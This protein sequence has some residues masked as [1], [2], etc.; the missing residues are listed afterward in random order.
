MKEVEVK[1]ISSLFGAVRFLRLK[2]PDDVEIMA[3]IY[4]SDVTRYKGKE[5]EA[6]VTFGESY[7]VIASPNYALDMKILIRPGL[8]ELKPKMRVKEIGD[9]E[10][11]GHLGHYFLGKGFLGGRRKQLVTV[12]YC[13][14]TD[15][16]IQIIFKGPSDLDLLGLVK[17]LEVICHEM[18]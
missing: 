3:T 1:A 10:L 17:S 16:T 6:Y 11:G 4:G 13:D 5:N 14:Q 15:R 2:V 9:I 7:H 8:K 18:E 12:H